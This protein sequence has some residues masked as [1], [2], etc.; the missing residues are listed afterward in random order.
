MINL[1]IVEA[2]L[3]EEQSQAAVLQMVNMYAMDAMGGGKPLSPFV[4]ENLLSGLQRHPTTMVFL[5]W[6]QKIPVGVAVCFLGFSTFAAKPL[7]NIHDIAVAP[8]SRGQGVGKA[9]LEAVVTKAKA[10]G[11]CKLTLEV[12][13]NNHRAKKTYLSFGFN[14]GKHFEGDGGMVFLTK[15]IE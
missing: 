4:R 13:Q 8:E 2:D 7:I 1:R 14:E 6:N 10:L 9:L 5:A 15:P 3:N 12:L 11:C